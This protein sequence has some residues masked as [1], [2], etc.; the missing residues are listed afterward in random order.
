[1]GLT[2]LSIYR[3]L[4]VLMAIAA[5]LILGLRAR[6]ELPSELDPKV[7]L[8]VVNV[9][10]P[11]P[12]AGPGEVEQRV[13]RP[14]EEAVSSVGNVTRVDSRSLENVSFVT[15]HL[16][17]GTDVNAAAADARAR[18]EAIRRELPE[19]IDAPQ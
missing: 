4:A 14:I 8:P 10:T 9:I 16:V 1:M 12:G 18:V 15:I 17:L 11:Y 7:D 5:I 13:T 6:M 3:P 2:R 19:E